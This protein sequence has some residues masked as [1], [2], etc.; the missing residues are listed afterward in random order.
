MK[1]L[2]VMVSVY[3]AGNFIENRLDNLRQS[4]MAKDT[5]V[6]VVNAN[7]PDP[8]DDSI[9]KKFDVRYIKLPERIGVYAAWNY[10]IKNS[11]SL[12]LT[13]ANA[14]DLIAPGGYAKLSRTLDLSPQVGFVY[15]SW[16]TT[17]RPNLTWE[18][19]RKGRA[20]ADKSGKPGT[21][22]GDLDSGGVGHF[23]MWRRSLH[24]KLGHFD[25]GFKAL[26]DADWWAR[27]WWL[28]RTEFRWQKE[29]L[30]CYLFRNGEN[31]WHKSISEDE[32]RLYHRKVSEY[33]RPTP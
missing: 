30:A 32:W 18:D 19:I 29:Y 16:Y 5:E 20:A 14:D 27:C 7:S 21:Y 15:P 2:V 24:E 1:K 25:D 10:I 22:K 6:W 23:P 13:N 33:Q 8:R 11:S 17:D 12:Y 31:L 3:N 9:P 4:T 26:G 28:G